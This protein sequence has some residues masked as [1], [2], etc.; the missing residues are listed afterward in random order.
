[1]ENISLTH[2]VDFVL[3]AGTPK[4][5]G[6]KEIKANRSDQITDFYK[7]LREAII[8]FHE[9]GQS[10]SVLDGFVETMTD[11]RKRRIYPSLLAGYQ[12][13]LDARPMTWFS[14]PK[15]VL[16]VG[17]LEVRINPEVGFRIEG[18]PH[19]L[20]LYFRGEPLTSKRVSIVLSLLTAALGPCRPGTVFAMLDVRHARLYT[21]KAPPNPRLSLLLRGEAASFATIYASV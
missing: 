21:I 15:T 8:D 17:D 12:R 11:E 3:K 5:T 14:P 2:F 16:P 20:K 18:T 9:K 19:V 4:L 7:P 6:V 13:F 10:I 1:M